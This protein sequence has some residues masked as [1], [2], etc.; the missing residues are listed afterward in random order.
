MFLLRD[1]SKHKEAGIDYAD[2]RRQIFGPSSLVSPSFLAILRI[3]S[4]Y[5]REFFFFFFGISGSLAL[6]FCSMRLITPDWANL[7]PAC[8]RPGLFCLGQLAIRKAFCCLYFYNATQW[9]NTCLDAGHWHYSEAVRLLWVYTNKK[10]SF[11]I[12][13]KLYVRHLLQT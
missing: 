2:L 6:C 11:R 3:S 5:Q 7:G 10:K 1:T 13:D 8:L 12:L 4:W 9:S